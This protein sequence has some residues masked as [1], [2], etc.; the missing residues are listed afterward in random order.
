MAMACYHEASDYSL[1]RIQFDKLIGSFQLVENKLVHLASEIT[2]GQLLVLQLG[3]LK[4]KGEMKHVQVSLTKRNNVY[5]ALEIARYP[6]YPYLNH[7]QSLNR[8]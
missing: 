3:R 7:W 6:Q 8:N 4:D 5:H 1:I 2:N